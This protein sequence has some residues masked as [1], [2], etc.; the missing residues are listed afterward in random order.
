VTLNKNDQ[1]DIILAVIPVGPGRHH[2][3]WGG[4]P[5]HTKSVIEGSDN[6]VVVE[7]VTSKQTYSHSIRLDIPNQS[8]GALGR[9]NLVDESDDLFALETE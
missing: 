3:G 8:G 4:T 5:D 2:S 9:V 6:I 1:R 7:L